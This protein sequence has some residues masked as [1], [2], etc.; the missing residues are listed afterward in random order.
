MY[1]KIQWMQ[2]RNYHGC[3]QEIID[4]VCQLI[5]KLVMDCA[6]EKEKMLTRE[7]IIKNIQGLISLSENN[8]NEHQAKLAAAKA[9]AL[10]AEYNISLSEIQ[11]SVQLY[12]DQTVW[13][14]KGK[15]WDLD[16]V[17]ILIREFFFVVPHYQRQKYTETSVVFFGS[18]ENINVATSMLAF[19]RTK[20]QLLWN[21]TRIQQNLKKDQKKAYYLGLAEGFRQKMKESR[22]IHSANALILI[23]Q[24]IHHAFDE[25]H[26]NC[27]KGKPLKSKINPEVWKQGYE[28]GKTINLNNTL[29]IAK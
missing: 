16:V 10:I 5:D 17:L 6:R 19:L 11:G 15:A 21:K 13:K 4:Y 18:Q 12:L 1:L 28:D 22:Q 25:K 24:E 3:S 8:D 9:A 27:K 26:K 14:G 29:K 23:N 20:F 2:S 7:S